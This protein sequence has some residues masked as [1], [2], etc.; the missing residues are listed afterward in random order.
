MFGLWTDSRRISRTQLMEIELKTE[1]STANP[2][3]VAIMAAR[4]D[5]MSESLVGK[6]VSDALHGAA[7]PK[8][9]VWNE[10][11]QKRDFINKLLRRGHFGP[12]EHVTAYFAVEGISRV[13]LAQA[14][15]H[16]VGISFDVQSM[17]YV[18]FDEASAVVPEAVRLIGLEHVIEDQM[19]D[20]LDRYDYLY[21]ELKA[22]YLN[23][24]F[25]ESMAGKKAQQDAR[26]V[27]PL[28][29]KVNMTFSAN[30]RTLMHFFDLR[31]NTKAQP[32]TQEF[33]EQVLDLCHEWS[34]LTFEGYE[35]HLNNNSLRAP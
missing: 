26:Y 14:T 17:R 3:D 34:P 33:A 31:N 24:G 4:G 6:S 11:D 5:Y 27:L 28:G 13:L 23:E 9:K 16:R 2:D 1:Y 15:R 22:H 20:S 10:E 30:A 19:I 35:A 12:F 7:E 29:T 25:K 8:M 18:E 21:D 32:E